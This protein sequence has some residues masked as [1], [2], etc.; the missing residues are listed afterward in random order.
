M[1]KFSRE[2]MIQRAIRA[3]V[4]L[5]AASGF[6]VGLTFALMI[7]S[8]VAPS[9]LATVIADRAAYPVASLDDWQVQAIAGIILVLFGLWLQ[10]LADLRELAAL[11]GD[12]GYP[13]ISLLRQTRRRA[14]GFALA[15]LVWSLLGQIPVSVIA[16]IGDPLGR[17]SMSL[18]IGLLTLVS[19]A[20][21][22]ITLFAF[23]AQFEAGRSQVSHRSILSSRQD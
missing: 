16:T 3:Q 15:A 22:G 12:P 23:R 21:V 7:W 10:A 13:P 11:S 2:R 9:S 6:L 19:A 8:L 1:K 5:T 4:G 14:I 20:L 18:Q 17:S